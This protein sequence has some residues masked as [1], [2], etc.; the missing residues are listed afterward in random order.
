METLESAASRAE[1]DQLRAMID[2]LR[3]EVSVLKDSKVEWNAADS[4]VKTP[5]V[6]DVLFPKDKEGEGGGD[7][8]EGMW[9]L[10]SE[11][12]T[13]G[14]KFGTFVYDAEKD[15]VF[16]ASPVSLAVSQNPPP[17]DGSVVS[18]SVD[19]S[20][21]EFFTGKSAPKCKSGTSNMYFTRLDVVETEMEDIDYSPEMEYDG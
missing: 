17:E 10:V 12:T 14:R 4:D 13:G 2:E 6:K 7:D 5:S 16:V 9:L 21:L 3:S 20:V 19:D 18:V 15:E 8:P 11:I 1:V